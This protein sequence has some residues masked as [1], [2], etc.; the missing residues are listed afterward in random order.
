MR[1][2][3]NRKS[4]QKTYL[5]LTKHVSDLTVS[6]DTEVRSKRGR[7]NK[8]YPLTAFVVDLFV[9]NSTQIL[10]ASPTC[11]A[12]ESF[13]PFIRAFSCFQWQTGEFVKKSIPSL[14]CFCNTNHR[15]NSRVLRI[16][17]TWRQCICSNPLLRKNNV[18]ANLNLCSR[19][20][21]QRCYC[22][23]LRRNRLYWAINTIPD[24]RH[25]FHL[26]SNWN[27]M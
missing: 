21:A 10:F 25:L 24:N 16:L 18:P 7:L 13:P 26:S 2:T 9:A 6:S 22:I 4:L 1:T 8:T 15:P 5:T 14:S 12:L 23:L 17:D 19:N 3:T 11:F 27:W 20:H